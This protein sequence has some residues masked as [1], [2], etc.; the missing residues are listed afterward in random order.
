MY[1]R[2]K[3][4]V[5]EPHELKM[6]Q[7]LCDIKDPYQHTNE[8]D[9]IFI[10]AMKEIISW[11]YTRNTFYRSFLDNSS[12]NVKNLASIEQ[13]REIPAI[14]ANFF[15]THTIKSIPDTDIEIT[16]TS[17]GTTGQKSQMYFDNWSISAGRRMV[18]DIYAYNN[19]YSAK[20]ANY[21]V[22]NYEPVEGLLRGTANTSK[23]LTKYAPANEIF[24]LL[25]S[26]GNGKHEFDHFGALEALSR[27]ENAKLPVRI[28]GFP[29]FVYFVIKR[30]SEMN[31]S[32][33]KLHPDSLV[34]FAGG[35]KGY[36]DQQIP[37]AKL[38][39]MINENLGIPIDRCRDAYGAVEH[40]VPYIEC[41]HHHLH[42]P[43]WSRATIR[44][45]Y[46]LEVLGYNKP[47][48]LS[49]TTPYITSAPAISVMM[50]DMAIMHPSGSCNCGKQTPWFEI[51]GRAGISKNKSCAVSATEL[52]KKENI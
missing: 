33:L 23:Y 4:Q 1:K 51:T 29:S 11:H 44:D 8:T 19:W 35:W 21:I 14:H 37:K 42:V 7:K 3:L 24:Y 27:F 18:D 34:L 49:F 28:I 40:S 50:G 13:L 15:K 6:V 48:F 43:T 41:D 17:S 38:Y 26:T 16:L 25:R 9:K 20:P 10:E 12:F 46:S 30:L 52:L 39:E 22:S 2:I 36:A 5:P 31:L 32:P 47:G 45:V